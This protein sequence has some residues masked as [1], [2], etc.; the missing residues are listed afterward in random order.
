MLHVRDWTQVV[1]VIPFQGSSAHSEM[2]HLTQFKPKQNR[3]NVPDLS[4]QS[5]LASEAQSKSMNAAFLRKL[6]KASKLDIKKPY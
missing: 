1:S 2:P 5:I 6:P 4:N 3:L